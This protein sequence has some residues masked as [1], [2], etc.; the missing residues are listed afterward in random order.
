ML[1]PE[2]LHF[3]TIRSADMVFWRGLAGGEAECDEETHDFHALES[4]MVWRVIK[5][6]TAQAVSCRCRN[7]RHAPRIPQS[8]SGWE[9]LTAD[10]GASQSCSMSWQAWLA[11]RV[12]AD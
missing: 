4:S 1:P 6:Q 12:Q 2:I 7:Q 9:T 5:G 8:E 3:V 11:Q 10:A